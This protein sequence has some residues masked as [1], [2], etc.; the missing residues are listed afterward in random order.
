MKMFT[1]QLA[2]LRTVAW[3]FSSLYIHKSSDDKVHPHMLNGPSFLGK[4]PTHP[5]TPTQCTY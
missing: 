1:L 3:D 4:V 5:H 2:W